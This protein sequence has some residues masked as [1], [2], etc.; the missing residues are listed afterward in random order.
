V[1]ELTLSIEYEIYTTQKVS[2]KISDLAAACADSPPLRDFNDGPFA[3]RVL[4]GMDFR[5]EGFHLV[6]EGQLQ[7]GDAVAGCLESDAS[8]MDAI[9]HTPHEEQMRSFFD[10]TSSAG[11]APISWGDFSFRDEYD[12]EDVADYIDDGD[13]KSIAKLDSARFAFHVSSGGEGWFQ[14]I[15]AHVIAY[16]THGLFIDPQSGDSKLYE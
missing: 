4:R 5:L 3:I 11:I 1:K 13:P 9:L 6:K 8:T 2:P 16:C 7:N 14:V 10:H 15:L 12:G